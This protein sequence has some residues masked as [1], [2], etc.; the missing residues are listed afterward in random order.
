[1]AAVSP[2]QI[3]KGMNVVMS[4]KNPAGHPERRK[5][6]HKFLKRL[7]IFFF[8]TL[9]LAFPVR[10]QE[11]TV[12]AAISLKDAFSDLGKSFEARQKGTRVQFNLGASGDLVRQILAGAPVEVFASAG[13]REMDE[14]ERKGFTVPGTRVNFAGNT[15]VL[16]VPAAAIFPLEKFS[17]LSR[18]EIKKIAIGNPATVP[19]GRYAV[20]ALRNLK[21]WEPLIDKLVFAENVRQVLDYVARNEVDAG[22]VYAT[23]A[24]TR[25]GSLKKVLS[26]PEGSHQPVVYP[27]AAVKGT[28]NEGP[29]RAF[30]SWVISAEGKRVL[31]RYGFKILADKR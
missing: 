27:I 1:M 18:P 19:A 5:G 10:A 13:L 9:A 3:K 11:I 29:A 14:L 31:A 6:S 16:A 2:K 28:K 15:V 7:F 4:R 22:L 23:D 25:A 21:L 20:Q 24:L 26:A 30:I 12:S 17:D 8:F